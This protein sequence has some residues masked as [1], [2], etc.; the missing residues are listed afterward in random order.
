MP[1]TE[2]FPDPEYVVHDVIGEWEL[3]RGYDIHAT[4]RHELSLLLIR[5]FTETYGVMRIR[6]DHYVLM[7]AEKPVRAA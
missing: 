1:R 6:N 7:P 3:D 5:A 2:R 4:D